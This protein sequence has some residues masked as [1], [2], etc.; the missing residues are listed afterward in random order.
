MVRT[1]PDKRQAQRYASLDLLSRDE[2]LAVMRFVA[3]TD[4]DIGAAILGIHDDENGEM[5]P[6]A[7]RAYEETVFGC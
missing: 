7:R 4:A 3:K 2:R 5:S 6:E 1:L